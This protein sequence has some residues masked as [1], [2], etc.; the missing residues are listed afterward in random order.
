MNYNEIYPCIALIARGRIGKWWIHKEY[1]TYRVVTKYY[2]TDN[3]R[4]PSQQANRAL[5]H[6]GVYNW[7][8]FSDEA[9]NFYNK[10][11]TSSPMSGYNRYLQLYLNATEPMIVYWD[12]LEKNNADPARLPAYMESEYFGGIGRIRSQDAYPASPP[13]GA[14]RFQPATNKFLGFKKDDGWSALGGGAEAVVDGWTSAGAWTYASANTINVPAGAVARFGI[15]DRVKFTQ[16]TVKY[17]VIVA[18]ADELITLA[19]NDDYAVVD[20]GISLNYY[21]HEIS[22]VGFP[23]WFKYTPSFGAGFPMTYTS[24]SVNNA[25]FCI[26]GRTM[27]LVID[28]Y[29]TTGGT[30]STTLKASFPSG[31][32]GTYLFAGIGCR[33]YDSANLCGLVVSM[34]NEANIFFCDLANWNLGANKQ[35]KFVLTT[36]IT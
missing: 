13:Y 30:A 20:A 14:I 12:T 17:G 26:N 4:S 24:V 5:M 2:V 31:V 25:I 1:K 15:G 35:I 9:K 29:G 34:S 32:S 7:H 23:G 28:A 3:P 21:S 36:D 18:V 33:L 10:M 27:V 6:D 11:R 19:G 8:Y 22:P 16:T